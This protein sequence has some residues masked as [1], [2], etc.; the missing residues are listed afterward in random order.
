MRLNALVLADAV[1]APQDGK[2]YIHGGGLTRVTVPLLPFPIPQLGVLVRLEI[3]E[4]EIGETHEFRFQLTDPDG[5]PVGLPPRFEAQIPERLPGAPEPE[6]GEQLFVLLAMNLSGIVV[7]R[8][9]LH[10]F[11]FYIDDELRDAIPLPVVPLTAEQLQA[12]GA[13]VG[14][15]PPRPATRPNRAARRHPPQGR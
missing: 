2:F 5:T 3:E 8:R 13:P 11:E 7:G 15:P 12:M 10:Q 9:G 14:L 6:E 4:T 1:S